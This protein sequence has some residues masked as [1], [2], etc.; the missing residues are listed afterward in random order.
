MNL[1]RKEF[2]YLVSKSVTNDRFLKPSMKAKY[3]RLSAG[4]QFL[5][6]FSC[7]TCAQRIILASIDLLLHHVSHQ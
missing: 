7:F 1:S 2:A 5:I 3:L 4:T 6:Y